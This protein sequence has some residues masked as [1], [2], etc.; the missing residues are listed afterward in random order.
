M[1][2]HIDSLY[3]QQTFSM[4]IPVFQYRYN[5]KINLTILFLSHKQLQVN[6]KLFS[7]RTQTKNF[8]KL[9]HHFHDDNRHNSTASEREHTSSSIIYFFPH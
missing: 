5:M 8:E 4:P 1:T 7:N 3:A 2:A 9:F 6:K